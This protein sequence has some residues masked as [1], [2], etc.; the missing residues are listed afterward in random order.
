MTTNS[1]IDILS[2]IGTILAAIAL[3]LNVFQFRRLEMSIRGNTYQQ[4]TGYAVELKKMLLEH[5]ELEYLYTKNVDGKKRK[6]LIFERFIGNYLDNVWYQ[7][8]Y[9]LVDD[10]L[11]NSY[12]ELIKEI[13]QEHPEILELILQPNFSKSFREHVTQMLS[14]EG[15]QLTKR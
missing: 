3:I 12:D 5:P 8:K 15:I 13:V 2:A 10:E 1:L 14:R 4:L 7:K 6:Q 11:W 9:G